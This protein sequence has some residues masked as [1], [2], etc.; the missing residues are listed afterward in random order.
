MAPGNA[1]LKLVYG[2]EATAKDMVARR[3]GGAFE[4]A[5]YY[6][7]PDLYEPVFHERVAP[8]TSVLMNCMYWD[9]KFPRLLTKQQ[10]EDLARAGRLRML[11]LG[12][13]SC[14]VGGSV[15]FFSH[16][17]EIDDPF[18][19]YDPEAHM[20]HH[21]MDDHGILVEGIENLPSQ[22]PRCAPTAAQVSGHRRSLS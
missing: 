3:D 13:V 15:E 9:A 22:L 1:D 14:D 18:Y 8:H 11:A 7:N 12:D 4:A 17:T 16:S 2:V 5:H 19:L 6:A 10:T 21:N 20:V